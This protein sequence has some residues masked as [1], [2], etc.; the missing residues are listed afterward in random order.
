M[1]LVSPLPSAPLGGA[2]VAKFS[3]QAYSVREL[4]TIVEKLAELPPRSITGKLRERYIA[5]ARQ[6]LMLVL[7]EERTLSY[8]QIGRLLGGRDH[9]TI[10]HGV[11]VARQRRLTDRKFARLCDA[12]AERARA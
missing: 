6:A 12:I 3:M 8:P 7:Y 9:T 11:R 5:W 4:A 2:Y 1:M 10:M